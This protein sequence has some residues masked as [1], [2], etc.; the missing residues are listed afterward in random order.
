MGTTIKTFERMIALCV[1]ISFGSGRVLAQ[2]STRVISERPAF[3]GT[4]YSQGNRELT[5]D[6]LEQILLSSIDRTTV[7]LTSAERSYSTV[8][9]IPAFIGGFCVGF[10]AFSKPMNMTL[11]V[12]GVVSIVGA[13]IVQGA[14]DSDLHRAIERYN[15]DVLVPPQV[16]SLWDTRLG[17]LRMGFSTEF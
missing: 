5:K 4:S 6:E 11:I 14:S 7:N 2:D 12:S 13:Y 1:L 16:G 15:T 9:F 10:G 8:A 3:L 17:S